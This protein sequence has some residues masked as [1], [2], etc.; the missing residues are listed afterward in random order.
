MY[1]CY[2]LA[3][4]NQPV[5]DFCVL[6]GGSGAY[7]PSGIIYDRTVLAER[8]ACGDGEAEAMAAAAISGARVRLE[9]LHAGVFRA[10]LSGD[11]GIS[12]NVNPLVTGA[13]G[14]FGWSVAPGTYRVAVTAG[15]YDPAVSDAITIPPAA[16]AVNVGLLRAGAAP[17]G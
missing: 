1:L 2:S 12:P 16:T 10:V 7:D 14:R 8:L 3:E 11:P 13:D 5:E 6:L 15:G 4:G 17:P 9:T